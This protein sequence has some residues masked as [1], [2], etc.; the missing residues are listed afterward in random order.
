L[1]FAGAENPTV[2]QLVKPTDERR[3]SSSSQRAD[4]NRYESVN[5]TLVDDYSKRPI[6]TANVYVDP[7]RQ[8]SHGNA[9]TCVMEI[10]IAVSLSGPDRVPQ[11]SVVTNNFPS[12]QSNARSAVQ[13]DDV[14]YIDLNF[15]SPQ[16]TAQ[17]S[18]DGILRQSSPQSSIGF[19]NKNIDY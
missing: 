18:T 10:N 2:S 5:R 9:R 14:R 15:Q 17:V 19:P 4:G 6:P 16:N 12:R 1:H 3:G 11:A 7:Y 8:P 13:F